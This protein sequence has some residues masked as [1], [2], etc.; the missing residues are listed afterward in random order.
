[1]KLPHLVNWQIYLF[2]LHILCNEKGL[3][4]QVQKQPTLFCTSK[5]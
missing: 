4:Y 2:F 3:I 1:M 5:F